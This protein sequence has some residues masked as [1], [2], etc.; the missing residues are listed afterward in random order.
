MRATVCAG[1]CAG[2]EGK[3]T[4]G[5]GLFEFECRPREWHGWSTRRPGHG[6][7]LQFCVT[8]RGQRH[9]GVH[10]AHLVHEA[11]RLLAHA[12]ARR[13]SQGRAALGEARHAHGLVL[14]IEVEHVWKQHG[15]GH[16]CMRG[17]IHGAL[18][19][20]GTGDRAASAQSHQITLQ[21]TWGRW[22]LE[23]RHGGTAHTQTPPAL[24]AV[25]A[26]ARHPPRARAAAQP[27][28]RTV[29]RAVL[30]AERVRDRVHTAFL[31]L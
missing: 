7:G 31:G 15:I 12:A 18:N 4:R 19:A 24:R 14:Q 1:A 11:R 8:H 21:H 23:L 30:A 5:Q 27:W 10:P 13:E 9:L 2:E 22:S 6:C 3:Q 26:A 20:S 16:T 29:R 25:H 28:P 17:V